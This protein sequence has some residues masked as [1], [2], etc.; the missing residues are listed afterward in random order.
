MKTPNYQKIYQDLL[1]FK[2]L[3]EYIP[4]P[5]LEKSIEIIR[6]NNLIA[7]KE[8]LIDSGITQQSRSYDEESILEILRYQK[9][10]NIN[11]TQLALEFKL[12]RNSV[13]KWK[14]IYQ[15]KI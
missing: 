2:G 1:K 4:V 7:K 8:R 12:S 15:Y 13:A 10:C 11:N 14:K 5:K 6:F 3:D 9:K